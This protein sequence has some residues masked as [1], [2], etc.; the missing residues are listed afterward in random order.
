MNKCG[1]GW[2]LSIGPKGEYCTACDLADQRRRAG[3][4]VDCGKPREVG[5]YCTG[6]FDEWVMAREL[7]KAG[8]NG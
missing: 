3:L 7:A 1:C 8:S 6:C 5:P 4:C 2:P